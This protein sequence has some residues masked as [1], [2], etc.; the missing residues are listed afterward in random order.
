MH[1]PYRGPYGDMTR[2]ITFAG[3]EIHDAFV[4]FCAEHG[5]RANFCNAGDRDHDDVLAALARTGVDARDRHWLIQHAIVIRQPQVDRLA[6]HGF[7]VT[8]SLSFAWGKGDMYGARLGRE[9]W[10]DLV[11]LNRL[12]KSGM[13]VGCG[14]DW[15]P[16]NMFEHMALAETHEFAGTGHRN[17]D[18]DHAVD[19]ATS[20]SLWTDR[21]A[22]T[23]GWPGVGSLRPGDHADLIVLDRDP[24]A[25]ALDDLPGTRVQKTMLGGRWVHET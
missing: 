11:P 14:S 3:P 5:L 23:L 20:V 24:H 8:T 22:E 4:G 25:C 1:E 17:D 2:G 15:G 12:L 13:R 19:R 21:A 16:K 18:E 10:R 6:E 9:I 7:D